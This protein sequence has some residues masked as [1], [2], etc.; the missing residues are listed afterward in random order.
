MFEK[1]GKYVLFIVLS[2]LFGLVFAFPL[3][4]AWNYVMP[5]LFEL[6]TLSWGHAFC[7]NYICSVLIKSV[8]IESSPKKD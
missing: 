6:N 5:H 7:L 8:L 2:A 1:L 4:W 3:M